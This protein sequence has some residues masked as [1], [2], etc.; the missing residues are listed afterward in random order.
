M[1]KFLSV[2]FSCL[3]PLCFGADDPAFSEIEPFIES[4]C[5]KCHDEDVQKGEFR[6]DTYYSYADVLKDRK[7]WLKVL[8][9]LETREMPTKKPFP[10]EE[11]Y[12][13]AIAWVNRAVND[14]DWEKLKHPGHVTLPRLTNVEYDRTVRD[15]LGLNIE[16]SRI[17]SA[18][19]EGKS[20][21]TNDRDNLFLSSSMLEKYFTA[22][23][24]A[25]DSL[26]GLHEEPMVQHFETEN[27]F[28][29]ES[30]SK[31][32]NLADDAKGYV[33]SRG[34]MT[35]YENVEAP[36]RGI[37]EFRVRFRS[38]NSG[39][40]GTVLRINDDRRGEL[41]TLGRDMAEVVLPVFLNPGSHQMAWNFKDY[42]KPKENRNKGKKPEYQPLP[43]DASKIVTRESTAQAPKFVLTEEEEKIPNLKAAVKSWNKTESNV[44]RP[45]E[46]LRLHGPEGNPSEL[47]RFHAYVI[48]RSK[49]LPANAK[50]IASL[51][52][53]TPEDFYTRYE[54]ANADTIADR[55][56]LLSFA[57]KARPAALNTGFPAIDWI[58]VTGPVLPE[59]SRW[60]RLA[61]ESADA[62][63]SSVK[64]QTW[65]PEF[66]PRAFRSEVDETALGKY[67]KVYQ[68]EIEKGAKHS[69]AARRVLL[70][71]LVSPRFLYRAEEI[72][73]ENG[74]KPFELSSKQL[75]SRLSYF[76]WQT[77][78]D[79][80][81]SEADLSDDKVV[82]TQINRMLKD[83]RSDIFFST[84]PGQWLG[85]EALGK[86]VIPDAGKFPLFSAD[87]AEDMK[88]ETR[89]WFRHIFRK[90]RPIVDLLRSG[91]TF[92][93]GNLALHY[94]IDGE[95]SDRFELVS[96]SDEQ[97][98]R[99]GGLLGMG[100]IL[101][102]TS[103]PVRTSPVLRGVFVME[104]LL[105]DD[106]G[107]PPADAGELPGNAGGRG[108]TLREELA[109]HRDAAACAGCHDK[110]DPIGFGLDHFDAVGRYRETDGGKP[111]DARGEL[112]DGTTFN[113]VDDL[114]N[115][116]LETRKD[117]FARIVV[118][119]LLSYALG[120]ELQTY[121]EPAI[122]GILEQ[123]WANGYPARAVIEA[124]VSSYP[125]RNQHPEAEWDF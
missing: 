65:F 91:E 46:W 9:Q 78:P 41:E 25:V 122:T 31:V 97:R 93:N 38:T 112:P 48:D 11:E 67:Q 63:K 90:N 61:R 37:Y 14:V 84:F 23:E 119:R 118:E 45:Y 33:L 56:K 105:G 111:V 110:I 34:Q 47:T 7:H 116:I 120:R 62:L 77:M 28:M 35:L 6:L 107:L 15:L 30:G 87:L 92:L 76:L 59:G 53:I 89:L 123:T 3:G 16:A 85:Y 121:D 36:H 81:L 124:I 2:L 64:W 69:D 100:S 10:A 8:E 74:D 68:E 19:G 75:A 109:M 108:K 72:P 95:F 22:A 98:T 86:S 104:R 54:A 88:S 117:D 60:P 114:R 12:E 70:S 5:F 83:W 43:A 27:M 102:A 42:P 113:G 18:D 24:W 99:R 94:G 21:F 50:R 1:K 55:K 79:R 115:Y 80:E 26:I 101:T 66:L 57:R 39:K 49:P 103:T 52:G 13:K 125:F 106:P 73:A 71:V 40:A 51:L 20:G 29:T 58:E 32:A 44:Q 4:Y 17:F 82:K 96:L